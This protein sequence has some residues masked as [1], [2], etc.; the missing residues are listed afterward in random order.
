ML[1]THL[2]MVQNSIH[3]LQSPSHQSFNMRNQGTTCI[4]Q[5]ILHTRRY[6]SIYFPFN[7]SI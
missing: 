1:P 7:Q 2:S 5:A 3:I 6:F 4:C